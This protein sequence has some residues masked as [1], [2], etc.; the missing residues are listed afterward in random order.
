[1]PYGHNTGTYPVSS[2]DVAYNYD[3]NPNSI[4]QQTITF[5]VP[6]NPTTLSS[7]QCVGG[8]VGIA[9]TGVLIF[10]A[11]DAGGR[12]AVAVEVQDKCDG[13]PQ[14]G[15]YYHYHGY[16]T[17]FKDQSKDGEHSD[18]LGYAF[19]GF[20]L[21]GLK[22]E[23]GVEL[24]S[25][26][27]DEC[28]GHTHTISWDGQQVEMYHYHMTRD[29][30]YTVSCF[31]GKA[32][33]NQL[34][35]GGRSGGGQENQNGQNTQQGQQSAQLQQPPTQQKPPQMTQMPPPPRN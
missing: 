22:D 27:L 4:K 3:R 7:P 16:S 9:T 35:A 5:S 15:G 2:K 11:F 24:S 14:E 31:R 17:C 28:H 33:V 21:Y 29:F 10:N 30:P 8:E 32:S 20:G 13:H 1:L 23:D 18:L 19:D 26:D 25:S 34:S 6:K 12:D